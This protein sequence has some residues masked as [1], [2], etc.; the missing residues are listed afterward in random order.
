[1]KTS[2]WENDGKGCEIMLSSVIMRFV[3][4]YGECLG[5]IPRSYQERVLTGIS[6][7]I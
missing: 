3:I 7:K 5:V 6:I 2:Y 4:N 1:L